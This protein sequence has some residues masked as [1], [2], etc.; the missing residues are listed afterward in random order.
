VL[1]EARAWSS[2]PFSPWWDRPHR[3]LES[4]D[5]KTQIEDQVTRT[6]GESYGKKETRQVDFL[7]SNDKLQ[8]KEIVEV[9]DI[10]G[11][12]DKEQFGAY[13][14]ALRDDRLRD[15]LG[16]ERMRYVFTKKAGAQASLK[17]FANAYADFGLDGRLTIEV[18]THDG[19]WLTASNKE[20]AMK[21][22]AQ[23]GGQ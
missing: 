14:D 19:T 10:D 6:S 20:Q 16:A 23:L 8:G 17:F 18:Y 4:S 21:L 15:K 13:A 7:V 22:V 5:V 1:P 2:E 9:K 11:M 12:I 3:R